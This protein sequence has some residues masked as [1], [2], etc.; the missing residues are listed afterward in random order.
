MRNAALCGARKAVCWLG[1]CRTIGHLA[2]QLCLVCVM[3]CCCKAVQRAAVV[4]VDNC[5]YYRPCRVTA[6]AS[7]F[8][9]QVL[10]VVL[11]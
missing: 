4:P 6:A 11:C 1:A 2:A 3:C 9:V 7:Q 10:L 5:R 8:A